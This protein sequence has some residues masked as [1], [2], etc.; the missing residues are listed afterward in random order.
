MCIRDRSLAGDV[1][2]LLGYTPRHR[3]SA[4]CALMEGDKVLVSLVGILGDYPPT[5]DEGFRQFAESLSQ[6][7]IAE[8]FRG[9]TPVGPAV[10]FRFAESLWRRYDKL[11][12]FPARL[13]VIGDAHPLGVR[14]VDAADRV[15]DHQQPGGESR[16]LVVA[17]PTALGLSLIHISEPTRPY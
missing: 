6:P 15:A 9:L 8:A 17:A 12:S 4:I 11:S 1:V 10:S 5:D 14:G 16:Q 7:D 13:L 3:R 2:L